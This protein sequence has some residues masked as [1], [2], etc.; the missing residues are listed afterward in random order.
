VLTS[1]ERCGRVLVGNDPEGRGIWKRSDASAT[2]AGICPGCMER[3]VRKQ[4]RD[5]Y[6][7]VRQVQENLARGYGGPEPGEDVFRGFRDGE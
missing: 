4:R 7:G 5:Y 1:C 3:E 2:P 6:R